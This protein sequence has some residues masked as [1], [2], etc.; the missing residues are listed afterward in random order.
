MPSRRFR[1]SLAIISRCVLIDHV[2]IAAENFV[3]ARG[4]NFVMSEL[5][6]VCAVSH[7]REWAQSVTLRRAPDRV[8][9]HLNHGIADCVHAAL[10]GEDAEFFALAV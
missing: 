10:A 6:E 4:R 2:V 8:P 3:A 5:H 1:G 9:L 7:A